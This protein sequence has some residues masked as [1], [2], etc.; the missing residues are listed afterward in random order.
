MI[1]NIEDFFTKGCGRCNRFATDACSTRKWATG[2]A[3][4]REICRAAG[5]TEEV[6][7]GHPCY[8]HNGRNIAIIGAF[9]GDFRLTFFNAALMTDPEGVLQRQ[10]PNSRHADGFRFVDNSAVAPLQAVIATYLL[11]AIGYADA[12]IKPIKTPQDITLPDALI[13][14]LDTDPELAEAFHTLTPGRQKSYVIN[15]NG[16]K[17]TA[18]QIARIT[19][20]RPH[21]LAGKGALER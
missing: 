5:L 21:I 9:L 17:T 10:G 4:L 20:F 18:T 2:L 11:E 15:L 19:K 13:E 1:T 3:H 14:A 12:G 16:A 6:K 7:W 8:T